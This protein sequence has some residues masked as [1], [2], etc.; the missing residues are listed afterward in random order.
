MS[1]VF[2][3]KRKMLISDR[4]SP[5]DV[6]HRQHYEGQIKITRGVIGKLDGAIDPLAADLGFP[7]TSQRSAEFQF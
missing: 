5:S 4:S 2:F 3:F 7:Q 1:I 6:V